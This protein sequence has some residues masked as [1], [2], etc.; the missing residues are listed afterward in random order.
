MT[1]L[2]PRLTDE[3]AQKVL[4]RA[5]E[6]QAQGAGKLTV[7]QVREIASEMSI[8]ASAVDQALSE[9]LAAG[10]PVM[11]PRADAAAA[12]PRPARRVVMA[13][14]WMGGAFVLLMVLF[15]IMRLFVSR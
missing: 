8:P 15:I 11:P 5:L 1:D 12:S 9:Y 6:L 4:A 7:A 13:L 2:D 3:D 10:E 14:A